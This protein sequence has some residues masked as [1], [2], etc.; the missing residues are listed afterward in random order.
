MNGAGKKNLF[1]R[2]G[3]MFTV[4]LISIAFV[5]L[6][7]LVQLITGIVNGKLEYPSVYIPAEYTTF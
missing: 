5:V 1:S 2:R 3:D 6:V 4:V 7:V